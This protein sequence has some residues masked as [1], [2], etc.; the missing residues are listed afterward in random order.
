M[1]KNTEEK[2]R[3]LINESSESANSQSS[4]FSFKAPLNKGK[5]HVDEDSFDEED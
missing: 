3:L 4:L 1:K 5:N 2:K